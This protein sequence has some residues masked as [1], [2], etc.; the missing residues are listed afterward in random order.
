MVLCDFILPNSFYIQTPSGAQHLKAELI[1]NIVGLE[2][3]QGASAQPPEPGAYDASFQ[4]QR[5]GARPQPG[6]GGPCCDRGLH[7]RG[8]G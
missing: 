6:S 7:P 3:H 1:Y 4:T 8:R 2:A 5:D